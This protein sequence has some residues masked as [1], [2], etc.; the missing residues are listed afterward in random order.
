MDKTIGFQIWQSFCAFFHDIHSFLRAELAAFGLKS[1]GVIFREERF[2][3]A[4]GSQGLDVIVYD[5]IA[6]LHSEMLQNRNLHI[7]AFLSSLGGFLFDQSHRLLFFHPLH[8][9]L[10]DIFVY[11]W[12]KDLQLDFRKLNQAE[13][14]LF[15]IPN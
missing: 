6:S 7:E 13:I 2:R 14:G 12:F 10:V 9:G 3:L 8:D 15:D 1:I 5:I 11:T 4:I